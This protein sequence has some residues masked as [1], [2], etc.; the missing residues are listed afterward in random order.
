M[1]LPHT[2]EMCFNLCNWLI[3]ILFFFIEPQSGH[4]QVILC[5]DLIENILDYSLLLK[6]LTISGDTVCTSLIPV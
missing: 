3:V 5:D 1:V 6:N 4:T 2:Q